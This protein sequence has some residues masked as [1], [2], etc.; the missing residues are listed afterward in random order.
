MGC[1]PS[2]PDPK[3]YP[4]AYQTSYGGRSVQIRQASQ[5]SSKSNK[6]IQ[7]TRT[8]RSEQYETP[9]MTARRLDWN[10]RAL[11]AHRVM[12]EGHKF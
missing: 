3:H 1:T 10:E 7:L 2:K 9:E 12:G 6:Q 8:A 11:N 5:Q 4:Q